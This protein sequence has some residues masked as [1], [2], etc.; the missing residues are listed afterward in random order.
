MR[1]LISISF[2]LTCIFILTSCEKKSESPTGPNAQFFFDPP[3]GKVYNFTTYMLDSLDQRTQESFNYSDKIIRKNVNIG[4]VND[5]LVLVSVSPYY[6]DTSYLRV[7]NGKDI[8]E[9]TDT[10]NYLVNDSRL[11]NMIKNNL[12][13]LT[14]NYV[15]LPR[16]L[17]SKGDN[18]EY[19][20]LS[21]RT[22]TVEVDTGLFLDFSFEI[23]GKNEGFENVTVPYGT[24]KAYKVKWS[25]TADVYY[26]G[27]K[28]DNFNMIQYIWLNDD[29]DWVVK[30]YKPTTKANVLGIV[31]RGQETVLVNVQ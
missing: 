6:S 20:I 23:K 1:K 14:Q 9:Y 2:I 21:R 30:I 5:A 11:E 13:K 31:D 15:W 12:K 10:T 29:L 7:V 22:Y 17:L 18:A 16:V 4:G 27:T 28:I 3:L 8:Y 19:I 25:L 26:H 24:F